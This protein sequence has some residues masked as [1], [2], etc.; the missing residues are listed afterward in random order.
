M[1]LRSM[2][3]PLTLA[4][5]LG[6]NPSAAERRVPTLDDLLTLRVI[7]GAQIS[8]DGARVAYTISET[9][10]AQ[11][12][13]VT[14]IWVADTAT[15][16]AVVPAD[17]GSPR[18]ISETFDEMPAVVDW[19]P[20]GLYFSALQKT[21][22]HLYRLD[23]TSGTVTRVSAPR[24]HGRIVH[25]DGRRV[26]YTAGSPRLLPELIV[27]DVQPFAPRTLTDS[28]TQAASFVLGTRELIRGRARTAPR[29]KGC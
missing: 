9:D 29:L 3:A 13:F 27:S 1:S 6:L 5:L 16:L 7:G 23:P 22:S 25:V 2:A 10:F 8:P 18:S 24:S 11:D 28:T 21:A 26:A 4:L 20:A 14:H 12:A 19:T 15:R 17:G